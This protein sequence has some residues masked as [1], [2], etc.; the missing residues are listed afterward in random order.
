M[1]II[2]VISTDVT[3]FEEQ[4][5]ELRDRGWIPKYETFQ[6]NEARLHIIMAK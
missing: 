4:V 5:S 2:V 6:I 1:R 3:K